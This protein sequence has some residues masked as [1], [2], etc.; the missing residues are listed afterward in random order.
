[1]NFKKMRLLFCAALVAS[2]VVGIAGSHKSVRPEVHLTGEQVIAL[3]QMMSAYKK[4]PQQSKH[5]LWITQM[6]KGYIEVGV[7][8]RGH[9]LSSPTSVY[10]NPEGVRVPF[11]DYLR[12]RKD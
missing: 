7:F 9:W 1:M 3:G 10:F 8:S 5:S 11:R 4:G 2:N 12:V 6:E